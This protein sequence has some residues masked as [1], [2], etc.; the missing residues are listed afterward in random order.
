LGL[1]AGLGPVSINF[2]F[3]W[4]TVDTEDKFTVFEI[5]GAL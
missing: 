2:A 1:G 4:D 3:G 5:S